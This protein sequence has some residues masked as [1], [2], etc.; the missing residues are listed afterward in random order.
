MP[1]REW[2]DQDKIQKQKIL[3]VL[4]DSYPDSLNMMEI[5][6]KA[7]MSRNTAP[8]YLS[9]LVKEKKIVARTVSRWEVYRIKKK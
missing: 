8:K 2:K 3:K 7:G 6:E 5:A 1:A 4:R 9:A